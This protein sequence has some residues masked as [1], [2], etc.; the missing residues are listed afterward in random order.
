VLTVLRAAGRRPQGA[1]R[2]V[3]ALLVQ[4]RVH[5]CFDSAR[6]AVY[7]ADRVRAAQRAFSVAGWALS[8]EGHLSPIGAIDLATGAG[9]RWMSS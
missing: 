4:L 3:D 1:R 6:S 8:D 5:G 9:T 7:D 2:L